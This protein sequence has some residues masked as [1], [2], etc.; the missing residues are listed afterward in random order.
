MKKRKLLRNV[1]LVALSAVLVGGT[2]MAFTGCN[3]KSPNVLDVFIFC[4]GAD[5]AT[6]QQI[7]DAAMEAFKKEHADLKFLIT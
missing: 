3:K 2:A 7:V 4:S 1:S 6:N 5:K